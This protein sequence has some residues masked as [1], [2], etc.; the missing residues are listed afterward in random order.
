LTPDAGAADAGT[1]A[2]YGPVQCRSNADCP[3]ISTCSNRAPGGV[4]FGCGSSR[5]CPSGLDCSSVGACVRDCQ[6]DSDCSAGMRCGA[7]SECVVRSCP[8]PAP[9]VCN[10]SNRCERPACPSGTCPAPFSCVGGVCVE[11]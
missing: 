8:C 5:D 10:S 2:S 11:P 4:C 6:K 1:P 9:Y 3:G 7:T